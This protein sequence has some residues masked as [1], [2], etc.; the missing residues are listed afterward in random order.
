MRI[1]MKEI[2]KMANVHRSTVDKVLHNREGVS[3]EVRL[4]IKKIIDKTGYTPNILGQGLQKKNAI[5]EIAVILIISDALDMIREGMSQALKTY[6]GFDIRIAYYYTGYVDENAQAEILE[7][8]IEKR[9]DGIVISPINTDK[10]RSAINKAT[11]VGIPVVTT[12]NFDI[13]DSRRLCFVGQDTVKAGRIAA[14]LMGSLLSGQGKVLLVAATEKGETISYSEGRRV[15]FESMIEE[16]YPNI[17]IMGSVVGYDNLKVIESETRTILCRKP[18]P[19]GILVTGGGAAVVGRLIKELVHSHVVKAVC[20][21]R[22]PEIVELI[23]EGVIN[24]TIDSDMINQGYLSIELLIYKTV[25][26]RKPNESVIYTKNEI[27][28]KGSL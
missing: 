28:V 2:A 4:K 10:I 19:D 1:T 9:V 18:L 24:F 3:D 15:G 8:L 20:F 17:E 5:I 22:Y 25:Y 14:S 12:M 13:P 21:E 26:N 16:E 23:R 11:D 27:L 6:E 7:Q